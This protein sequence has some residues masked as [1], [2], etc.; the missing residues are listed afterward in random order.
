VNSNE[1]GHPLP[2]VGILEAMTNFSCCFCDVAIEDRYAPGIV[3][4]T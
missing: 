3:E 2:R 1:C 4:M